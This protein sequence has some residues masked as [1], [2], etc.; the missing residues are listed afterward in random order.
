[1]NRK[2]LLSFGAKATAAILTAS[3]LFFLLNFAVW[4]AINSI[5]WFWL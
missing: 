3:I 2:Y 4:L 5:R 1:M